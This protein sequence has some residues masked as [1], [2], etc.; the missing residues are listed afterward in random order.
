MHTPLDMSHFETLSSQIREISGLKIYL[1]LETDIGSSAD[2]GF[3]ILK[4]CNDIM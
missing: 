4:Y 2:I 3:H 1:L